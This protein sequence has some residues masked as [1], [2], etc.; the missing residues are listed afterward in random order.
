M[1]PNFPVYVWGMKNFLSFVLVF[2]LGSRF[3]HIWATD[4]KFSSF[5]LSFCLIPL[6]CPYLVLVFVHIFGLFPDLPFGS[7]FSPSVFIF[8]Q[9]P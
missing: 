4:V 8:V 3:A 6:V 7:S 1:F 5:G 2:T 9:V